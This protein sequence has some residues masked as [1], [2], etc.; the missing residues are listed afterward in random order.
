MRVNIM[1]EES[2][3]KEIQKLKIRMKDFMEEE[4]NFTKSL[5]DFLTKMEELIKET[6]CKDTLS[7]NTD[8]LLR[9]RMEAYIALSDVLNMQGRVEHERSHLPESLG[10]LLSA[11]ERKLQKI[12]HESG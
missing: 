2:P 8:K 1:S 5:N 10:A 4:K 7:D 9:L 11:M 12:L 3:L 6:Q